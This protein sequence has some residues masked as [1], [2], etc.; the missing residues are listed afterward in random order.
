MDAE[1]DIE[2]D[3]LFCP[4]CNGWLECQTV[5]EHEP[6]GGIGP[7]SFF[8]IGNELGCPDCIEASETEFASIGTLYSCVRCGERFDRRSLTETVSTPP[9]RSA[10]GDYAS[11]LESSSERGSTSLIWKVT[12]AMVVLTL[13]ISGF[14]A[15]VAVDPLM[16]NE[17]SERVWNSYETIVVFR[18][19]DTQP[20]YRTETMKAVDRVFIEENVPV[21][22]GVI[23]A[24]GDNPLTK[25]GDLCSYLRGLERRHPVLFEFALHGYTHERLT[26]FH[27]GSEFGSL[28]YHRQSRRIRQGHRILKECIGHRVTTFIPPMDTYDND[29][30]RTLD[31]QD[32]TLVSGGGWF[33]KH[34][35][36][37]TG[38]FEYGGVLHIPNSNGFVENWST[39]ELYSQSELQRS[40]D[41]AYEND[42]IYVQ[43]LHYPQFDTS[44]KR[45][46]L[47]DL[48]EYMKSK[49]DVKFTTLGRLAERFQ[50]NTIRRTDDGWQLLEPIRA[51]NDSRLPYDDGVRDV[52]DRVN[53]LVARATEFSE[54]GV[55]TG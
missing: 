42:S 41:R 10:E 29:T 25:S 30:V 34:Y 35:Y 12:S 4:R 23:P 20:Y 24:V 2:D 14:G 21:T 39:N 54:L 8:E 53:R 28:P 50:E 19:D 1:R 31:E 3:L 55:G 33:T 5:L 43:M 11:W 27:N 26:D 48:I 22:L 7:R 44:E 36:N 18:N 46:R 16:A 52:F 13:L 47:R 15:A 49:G 40:F 9:S 51:S 38:V 6:C 37:Q 17:P 32:F 45:D